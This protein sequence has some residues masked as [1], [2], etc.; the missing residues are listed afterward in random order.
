MTETEAYHHEGEGTFYSDEDLGMLEWG[1]SILS[2]DVKINSKKPSNTVAIKNTV[3]RL[4]FLNNNLRKIK[5]PVKIDE[6]D[7]PSVPMKMDIK[8]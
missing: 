3:F 7:L 8:G 5:F 6:D 1:G 4:E 2:P